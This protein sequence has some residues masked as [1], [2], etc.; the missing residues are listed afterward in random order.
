MAVPRAYA[1]EIPARLLPRFI[2]R[3]VAGVTATCG[4]GD[5]RGGG[6]NGVTANLAKRLMCPAVDR[7]RR[8]RGRQPSTRPPLGAPRKQPLQRINGD[9]SR[10]DSIGEVGMS[11]GFC[12]IVLRLVESGYRATVQRC[13]DESPPDKSPPGGQPIDKTD[14]VEPATF[15]GGS[16]EAAE[17]PCRK[18][19]EG[20]G[21][22][23][24]QARRA[25]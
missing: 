18:S 22:N 2:A 16:V 11:G 5:G 3:R 15:G 21:G 1:P 17:T 8:R 12:H 13:T 9:A 25:V 14:G 4:C 6:S 23:D 20:L 19:G 24:A 7:D 10:Q